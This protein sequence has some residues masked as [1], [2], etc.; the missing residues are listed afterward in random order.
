MKIIC[1]ICSRVKRED[2]GLLPARVRYAAPH[3]A[4][5]E[6]I[7]QEKGESFYIL[8]GK[9]G[10]ISGDMEIPN[11]DY[12]LE[13]SASEPLSRVI[14]EQLKSAGVTEIDFYTEQKPTWASYEAAITKGAQSA[15]VILRIHHLQ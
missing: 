6:K 4:A 1:T 13:T 8:S 15:E 7:A 9:Y 14:A 12:Y 10:V 2:D 11:Y 5:T 3:I